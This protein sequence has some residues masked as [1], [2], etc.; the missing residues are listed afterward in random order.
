VIAGG[1]AFSGG[2]RCDG[3]IVEACGG[4]SVLELDE[5]GGVFMRRMK[6]SRRGS[7]LRSMPSVKS[8]RGARIRVPPLC[9]KLATDVGIAGD[10]RLPADPYG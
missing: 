2:F 7:G 1:Q 4:Q 3:C 9:S 6:N 5:L 10:D 8:T